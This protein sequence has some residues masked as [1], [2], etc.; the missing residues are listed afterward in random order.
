MKPTK[1]SDSDT[2]SDSFIQLIK[3]MRDD[4]EINKRVIRLLNSESYQRRNVL[5]NWLEQLRLQAASEKLLVALSSL[6]DEAI[7]KKTLSMIN[8]SK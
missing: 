5:N 2:Q 4:P 3:I 1:N 7:A 6:F 8:R